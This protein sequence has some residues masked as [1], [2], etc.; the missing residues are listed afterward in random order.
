MVLK[1]A[2]HVHSTYS[3]GEMSLREV[4]ERLVA[5]GCRIICMA[6]HADTFDDAKL[7]AY[8]Q[9]CRALS[10]SRVRIVPGLEYSC[11][12]RMHIVGYG[13]QECI[14]SD[15]PQVVIERIR[16]TGGVSV[17]AHP[18]PQH[19]GPIA[20]FAE[21]PDGIEVWNYKYDGVAAPRPE[22]FQ[23]VTSLQARRPDLRA[24]YGID[25]HWKKQARDLFVELSIDAESD[26]AVLDALRQGRFV[27]VSRRW[28]L[29]SDGQLTPELLADFAA[30]TARAK[31]WRDLRRTVKRWLGPYGRLLPASVKSQLRR[32]L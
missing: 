31:P 27:G 7:Q 10:D 25:L 26:H 15:D 11:R 1:A 32:F 28:R 16:K 21:L 2:L 6:D 8:T 23:L 29:P 18:A 14:E 24:F 20:D 5:D 17:I 19:L 3:D 22:V 9:E 30:R 4:C 13:V 12:S